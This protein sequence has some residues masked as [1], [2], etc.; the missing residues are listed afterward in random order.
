MYLA[1]QSGG[2]VMW[3]LF[4]S[5]IISMAC[6]FERCLYWRAVNWHNK[7]TIKKI[8]RVYRED[9][10]NLKTFL[11][12]NV[13]CPLSFVLLNSIEYEKGT[14]EDFHLAL[15]SSIQRIIPKLKKFNDLFSTIIT[16]SPLLGLLGTILGLI[17]SFSLLDFGQ[18]NLNTQGVTGG[19]SEALVSTAA[20]L[21]IAIVTLLFA[22]FFK[23]LYKNQLNII[24]E[25]SV[26]IELIRSNN[27]IKK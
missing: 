12:D 24:E 1:F 17:K 13:N 22:N 16:V 18:S 3:P 8:L 10:N 7:Y 4:I 2:L 14:S 11:L 27:I 25:Y 26:K 9:I 19:I 5:S 21:I 6:I 23:S 15:S 20:G